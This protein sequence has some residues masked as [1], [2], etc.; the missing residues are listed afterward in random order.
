MIIGKKLNTIS[1]KEYCDIH[2]IKYSTILKEHSQKIYIPNYSEKPDPL[3]YTEVAKFPEIFIAVLNNV[4]IIGENYIIFDENN[5]CIYDMPLNDDEDKFYLQYNNTTYVDKNITCIYY[6]EPTY[7]IEEGIMLIGACSYN[8]AHFHTEVLS[9]LCLINEIDEYNGV[10]ILIDDVCLCTPAFV[11]ELEML[12]KNGRKIIPIKKGCCYNINKLVYISDLAIYPFQLKIGCWFKNKD[13]IMSDLCI[14]PLNENLSIK[15]DNIFRKIYISR[16]NAINP[17]LENQDM[18]EQIFAENGYE[19]IF[20]ESMSFY[21][22]LKI[23]SEAEFIAGTFGA[24]LTNIIF[25]NK[26]AKF[27]CIQPKVIEWPWYSNIAGILGQQ[28]YFLDAE[29]S[30]YT[31]FR[32]YQNTFRLDE[33]FLRKFLK[34]LP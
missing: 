28:F 23:F 29:L 8:F 24:G 5:Y 9:K 31:P 4:N 16:R 18:V 14:K 17:R 21:D 13:C 15:S 10:P 27:I 19:I 2:N 6:N 20:T 1:C 11:E 7:T 3:N 22:K 26:N 34:Q 12:N 32:Y 30:K 33:D 25:A